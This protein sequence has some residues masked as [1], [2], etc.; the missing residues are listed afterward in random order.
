MDYKKSSNDAREHEDTT[1]R[2]L[3]E[4]YQDIAVKT[5]E[6]RI[7]V[8]LFLERKRYNTIP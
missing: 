5:G 4:V 8:N 3:Q 1:L 7:V 2:S 6:G